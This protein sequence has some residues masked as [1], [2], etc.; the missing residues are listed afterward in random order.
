MNNSDMFTKLVHHLPYLFPPEK[1]DI[2]LLVKSFPNLF[3]DVPSCST[4]IEHVI[5]VG[6]ALPAFLL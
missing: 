3:S 1:S 2:L 5:N 6:T 4:V